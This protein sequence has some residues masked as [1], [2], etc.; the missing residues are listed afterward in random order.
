MADPNKSDNRKTAWILALIA[1]MF[2]IGVFVKR[3]WFN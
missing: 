1:L 2:F 3:L